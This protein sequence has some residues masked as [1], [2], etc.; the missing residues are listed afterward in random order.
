MPSSPSSA[1]AQT[2]PRVV[3]ITCLVPSGSAPGTLLAIAVTDQGQVYFSGNP[4]STST[5]AWS[6]GVNVLSVP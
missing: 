2:S 3:G 6:K 1:V 4:T 5:S